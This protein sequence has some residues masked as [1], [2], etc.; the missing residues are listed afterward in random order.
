VPLLWRQNVIYVEFFHL[1]SFKDRRIGVA[2]LEH[3]FNTVF[4][5]LSET[6]GFY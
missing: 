1:F 4:K 5:L 3:S 6:E 2:E